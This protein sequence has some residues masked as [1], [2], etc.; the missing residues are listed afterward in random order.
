MI[1]L[2]TIAT[3]AAVLM[4]KS[5]LAPSSPLWERGG[6]GALA[7]GLAAGSLAWLLLRLWADYAGLAS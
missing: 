4:L 6:M 2:D 1:I 7:N 5:I 3:F